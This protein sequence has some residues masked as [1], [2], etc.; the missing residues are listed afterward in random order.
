M[1]KVIQKSLSI[2]AGITLIYTAADKIDF[3]TKAEETVLTTEYS[4]L[5]NGTISVKTGDTIKWYV[6][7]P[8]GTEPK[9]CGATIK[10]PDLGWGTDSHNKEEGHLTLEQ[11][12]NFVYEFTPEEERDILFTCW[13]GS[14]CHHNYIHVT[15]DGTYSVSKP[16][17]PSDVLA[18][19][20]DTDVTV[21]FTAPEPPEGASITGY[22]VTATDENGKRQKVVVKESPAVFEGLDNSLSY[23]FKVVTLATS[24]DSSG[25]NEFE[26]EAE[27]KSEDT[28]PETQE[29]KLITEYGKL[30]TDN[31]TVRAGESVKWYVNVP[32]DTEPK[33][34][35]ATIKIP[36]L[37]FGTDSNNK[38]EG[39][40]TLVKGENFV[41]EFTPEETGDILFTCWMGSK[42]HYNYIHVTADGVPDPDAKTG[43]RGTAMSASETNAST[44]ASTTATNNSSS[45]TT[46]KATSTGQGSPKT[47]VPG[48]LTAQTILG[49]SS[50]LFITSANS[51]KK[52][53]K[54]GNRE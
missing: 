36:G 37:G 24:G 41:Y 49:I 21:S 15:A 12:E 23:S 45:T 43:G 48:V 1:N 6:N 9:G 32:D 3:S 28:I 22:K 26:L 2:I 25:E 11:G 27:K 4:D 51:K 30:W 16:E 34:C 20:N 39:H 46:A 14:G 38:E 5:W 50:L 10:I 47:G 17:D 19:R 29:Q 8:E 33:G 54:R 7:V 42:C 40:V 13:M 31:I 35:G 18:E 44:T 52:T 53:N